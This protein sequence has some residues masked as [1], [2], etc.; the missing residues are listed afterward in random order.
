MPR[1]LTCSLTPPFQLLFSVVL[2]SLLAL[3]TTCSLNELALMIMLS[4]VSTA[5]LSSRVIRRR[6]SLSIM[7]PYV[8]RASHRHGHRRRHFRRRR[9]RQHQSPE[10][11]SPLPPPLPL[12]P[13][14]PPPLL[15]L[16][17]PL[18]G[19]GDAAVQELPTWIAL[20]RAPWWVSGR[21][22]KALWRR[23]PGSWAC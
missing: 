1:S 19:A 13:A 2:C 7:S 17:P 23:G 16:P 12:P 21:V 6:Q 22:E 5:P 10:V 8:T 9:R 4:L 20:W 14:L 3:R 15:L 11:A 18:S